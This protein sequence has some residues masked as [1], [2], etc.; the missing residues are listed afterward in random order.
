MK[1]KNNKKKTEENLPVEKEGLLPAMKQPRGLAPIDEEDRIL[2]RLKLLQALSPETLDK[3]GSSGEFVNSISGENF[4]EKVEFIPLFWT[5]SRILWKAR[6][7]GGGIICRSFDGRISSSRENCL[8]CDKRLW[9]TEGKERIQP[10]CTSFINLVTLV[11]GR[12][13]A[14]SF[15]KSSYT[16]GKRFINLVTLKGVDIF[17]FVYVLSSQEA[18]TDKGRFFVA[19][20]DDPSKRTDE[21]SLR[22]ATAF[23]DRL[24]QAKPEIH[25][26]DQE[27]EKEETEF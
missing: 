9:K 11:K 4:K 25:Q 23:Y 24:V 21:K 22:I 1:K 20:I 19:K 3:Q 6:D 18:T 16:T 8:T 7:E 27:E 5:K 2:P 26:Q 15:G 17:S 12:P 10:E 13:V 14:I